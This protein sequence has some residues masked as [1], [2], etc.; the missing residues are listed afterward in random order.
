[1]HLEENTVYA[2]LEQVSRQYY[3]MEQDKDSIVL[4]AV[5]ILR[6]VLG[7]R[8]DNHEWE[9]IQKEEERLNQQKDFLLTKFLEGV[10]ADKDYRRKDNELE[11]SLSRIQRKKEEW[12]QKEWEKKSLERRIEQIKTR[13]ESGGVEKAAAVQMLEDIREIRVH[14]WQLEFCFDPMRIL[15]IS[16]T[17]KDN[18]QMLQEILHKEFTLWVDY[19]FSPETERGRYLD[20]R[21]IMEQIKKNP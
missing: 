18:T 14:E 11:E 20:R 8:V 7:S 6:K 16:D 17:D 4:H 12:K 1:M 10:I 3:H 5:Q 9:Q 19:P 21:R 15:H 2:L 13:L